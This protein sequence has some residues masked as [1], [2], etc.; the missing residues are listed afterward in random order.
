ML[1]LLL[2]T[3]AALRINCDYYSVG[4]IINECR[5]NALKVNNRSDEVTIVSGTLPGILNYEAIKILRINSSPNLYFLPNGLEKFFSKIDTLEVSETGLTTLTATDLEKFPELTK[6]VYRENQIK[7]LDSKVFVRNQKIEEIDLSGNK[8]T[9]VSG[10]FF[11]FLPNLKQADL[12]DNV[13]INATAETPLEILKL[14]FQLSENCGSDI[15]FVKSSFSFLGLCL[16]AALFL[17]ALVAFIKFVI[18][19]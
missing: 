9:R 11:K 12:S 7:V 2:C 1:T 16:V 4:S 17:V 6:L 5:I 19:K 10:D 13:C 14:K 15:S 18:K 8:L 3:S